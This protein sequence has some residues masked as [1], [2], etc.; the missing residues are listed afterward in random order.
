MNILNSDIFEVEIDKKLIIQQNILL[1]GN[2]RQVMKSTF[3]EKNDVQFK[4]ICR[5]NH[6]WAHIYD[7]IKT[8]TGDKFDTLIASNY[9]H[10]NSIAELKLFDLID[11]VKK[12]FLI[13]PNVNH[14][15]RINKDNTL[16]YEELSDDEY[17]IINTLFKKYGFPLHLKHPRTG[18]VSIFYFAF[19]KKLKV[20]IYGFDIDGVDDPLNQHVQDNHVIDENAHSISIE[21]KI[22]KKLIE[23]GHLFLY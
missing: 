18:L 19:I 11:N 23:E 3:K 21:S 1:I 20:Y 15:Y 4:H 12:V 6:N 9:A 5:F 2:S 22:L 10:D 17:H 16:I 13:C 14:K 7:K 8:L